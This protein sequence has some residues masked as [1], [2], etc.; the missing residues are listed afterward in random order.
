[1]VKKT[2]Q[3]KVRNCEIPPKNEK[4]KK[5]NKSVVDNFQNNT[6]KEIIKGL[7]KIK[8]W[9]L[10]KCC[11]KQDPYEKWE[12]EQRENAGLQHGA[13]FESSTNADSEV[14]GT[15]LWWHVVLCVW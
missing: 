3:P 7:R 14:S 10:C 11:K 4:N 15:G 8:G 6:K 2:V 1:M 13:T 12:A 9:L 5:K